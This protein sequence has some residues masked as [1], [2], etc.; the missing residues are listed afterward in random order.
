MPKQRFD[1]F[2][3]GCMRLFADLMFPVSMEAA[4]A[5]YPKLEDGRRDLRAFRALVGMYVAVCK[6]GT[7]WIDISRSRVT[8]HTKYL[9]SCVSDGYDRLAGTQRAAPPPET[10]PVLTTRQIRHRAAVAAAR[11]V[12]Y[13]FPAQRPVPVAPVHTVPL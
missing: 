3:E 8:E 13:G 2:N 5:L 12:A 7:R 9:E 6:G 1:N 10:E 11:D 4:D